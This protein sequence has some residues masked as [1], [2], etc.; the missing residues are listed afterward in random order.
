L[1][2]SGDFA[3]GLVV[4][5]SLMDHTLPYVLLPDHLA[6]HGGI[7][8]LHAHFAVLQC[9][10]VPDH[11]LRAQ[12]NHSLMVVPFSDNGIVTAVRSEC[13]IIT[14]NWCRGS[15]FRLILRMQ[16]QK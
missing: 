2:T 8:V 15:G 9:L 7:P 4:H 5:I 6:L 3:V 1:H 13:E 10:A 12:L 11:R 14:A 16:D